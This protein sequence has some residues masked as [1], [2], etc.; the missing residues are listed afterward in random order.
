MASRYW[1]KLYHE[2]LDDP[3]MGRLPDALF[4]RAIE[5]FLM[6]GENGRDGGLPA[7]ADM[8]WRLHADEINLLAQM[9]DLEALNILS[10]DAQGGWRVTHF[11]KRQA[12][13]PMS[14][15]VRQFRKEQRRAVFEADGDSNADVTIRYTDTDIDKEKEVEAD[16]SVLQ[17]QDTDVPEPLRHSKVGACAPT[18]DT[19]AQQPHAAEAR[20][21]GARAKGKRDTPPAHSKYPSSGS[22]MLPNSGHLRPLPLQRSTGIDTENNGLVK[23]F[24]ERTGLPLYLGGEEKWVQALARMQQAGVEE[25]DLEQAIDECRSKGLTIAS[26]ASVVTPAIIARAKRK[27]GRPEEDYRR[28][29]KGEYGEFGSS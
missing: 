11:A 4:R 25:G 23:L 28:Y 2:I 3:K 27:A 29:L 8:A 7:L 10:R 20:V 24:V 21:L 18:V 17:E 6:A 14:E 12:P 5:F 16:G 19:R 15:R 13:S 22:S 1:I 26:L 9:E